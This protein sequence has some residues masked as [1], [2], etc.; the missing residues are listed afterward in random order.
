[1]RRAVLLALA[2]VAGSAGAQVPGPYTETQAAEGA[3]LFLENCARCHGLRLQGDFGPPLVGPPFDVHWRG[4]RVMELFG[5]IR[6]NMPADFPG[7]L[8]P[9]DYVAILAFILKSNGV[10]SGPEP[11]APGIPR[12][13][14][15]PDR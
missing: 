13:L 14:L 5:F 2:L 15:I 8:N 1:M 6:T 3:V 7:T 11:L 12:A 9:W 10:P 4:G